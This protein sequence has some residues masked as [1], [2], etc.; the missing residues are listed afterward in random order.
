MWGRVAR[1]RPAASI[2][3]TCTCI[4]CH[5]LGQQA[6]VSNSAIVDELAVVDDRATVTCFF[7]FDSGKNFWL[8]WHP[9]HA[10]FLYVYVTSGPALLRRRKSS[11]EFEFSIPF[12][13]KVL[14]CCGVAGG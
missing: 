5:S 7:D 3:R 10:Y 11:G 9:A 2:V 4:Q 14:L 12:A 6:V 1:R 8:L 13:C